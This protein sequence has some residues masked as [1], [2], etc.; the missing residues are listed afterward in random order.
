MLF[1]SGVS[2]QLCS[3][4][5]QG[6]AAKGRISREDAATI[7]VEALDAIPQ[8]TLIFEVICLVGLEVLAS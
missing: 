4:N 8:K 2:Y 6:V 5:M 3:S 1:Y 7:C